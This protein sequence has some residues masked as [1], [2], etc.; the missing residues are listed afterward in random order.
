MAK[1]MV[2]LIMVLIAATGTLS[3][4]GLYA[5]GPFWLYHML[6]RGGFYIFDAQ[7]AYAQFLVELPVYLAIEGGIRDLNTLIRVHSFGLIGVPILF[8]CGAL[9]IRKA[10]VNT[11]LI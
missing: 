4:R 11:V 5:D 2:L 6:V 9:L 7:R 8:W 3:A 10:P 1:Y